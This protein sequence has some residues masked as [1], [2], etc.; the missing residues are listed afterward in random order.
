MQKAAI[1]LIL[2]FTFTIA[3]AIFENELIFNNNFS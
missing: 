1:V 3:N 2:V